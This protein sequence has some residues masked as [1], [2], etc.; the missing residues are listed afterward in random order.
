MVMVVD[1]VRGCAV[2]DNGSVVSVIA[3]YPRSLGLLL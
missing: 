1:V 2:N 3:I